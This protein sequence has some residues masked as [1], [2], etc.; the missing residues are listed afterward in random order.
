FQQVYRKVGI[1]LTVALSGLVCCLLIYSLLLEAGS[2]AIS[3]CKKIGF[4]NYCLYNGTRAGCYC[5]TDPEGLTSVGLNCQKGLLLS[6]VL[7]YSSLVTFLVGLLTMTLAMFFNEHT[8]W[9]LAQVFNGLSLAGLSVGLIVYLCLTWG[10][11]DLSELSTGFLAL[12]MAIVGLVL[13]SCIMRHY[14]RLTD[15]TL[16][17]KTLPILEDR[18][19]LSIIGNVYGHLNS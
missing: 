13:L 9:M 14:T 6:L 10:L 15:K 5:I 8:L 19:D 7:T 12:L 17:P 4:Y 11:F 18:W 3:G 1:L 2:I 16:K